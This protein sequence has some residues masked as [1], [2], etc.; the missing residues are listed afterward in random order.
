MQSPFSWHYQELRCLFTFSI[1]FT[2]DKRS[3]V[4]Q[5]NVCTRSL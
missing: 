2:W 5:N 4:L 1:R 3:C